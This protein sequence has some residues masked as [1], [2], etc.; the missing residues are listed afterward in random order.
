M[1]K[2][3]ARLPVLLAAALGNYFRLDLTSS[4]VPEYIMQE[5]KI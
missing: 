4:A 2:M 3:K 5:Q 1:I